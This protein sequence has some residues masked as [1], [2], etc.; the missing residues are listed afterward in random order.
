MPEGFVDVGLEVFG[1]Q[2]I[3]RRFAML[4]EQSRDLSEP[5]GQLMDQ[6]LDSVREQFDTEGAA[7]GGVMWAPLSDD[8]GAWKL[9]HYPGAPILVRDGGMRT[10]MLDRVGAVQVTAEMA[11]YDPVSEIA[12]Y[13]QTGAD[14]IGPAWGRGEYAHH[15]PARKMVDLSDEFKH[16]A[17]DRTFA[18]WMAKQLAVDELELPGAI[19]A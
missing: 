5:L 9:A 6:I 1:E 17:V 16:S 10:A 13:H 18:R 2:V 14:W 11:V 3:A 19:A 4:D 12:G 8:Y 7:A 15:L